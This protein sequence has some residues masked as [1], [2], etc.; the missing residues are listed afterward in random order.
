MAINNS[1]L[2]VCTMFLKKVVYEAI[3]QHF[4]DLDFCRKMSGNA[5]YSK[6]I[7]KM[8]QKKLR[9]SIDPEVK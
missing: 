1:L 7:Q 6:R 2:G 4:F 3:K 5:A 9:L 8:A